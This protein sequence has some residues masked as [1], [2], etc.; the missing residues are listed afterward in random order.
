MCG[1][2]SF[3]DPMQLHQIGHW[4]SHTSTFHK[5]SRGPWVMISFDGAKECFAEP[6]LW[7]Y[8]KCT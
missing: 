6:R 1:D 5:G 8:A 3:T 7:S 2:G 4:T